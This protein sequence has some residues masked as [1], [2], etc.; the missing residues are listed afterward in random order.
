MSK[1]I[2]IVRWYDYLP[3]DISVAFYKVAMAAYGPDPFLGPRMKYFPVF[4]DAVVLATGIKSGPDSVD[5]GV[6]GFV[7][8]RKLP[9]T[10]NVVPKGTSVIEAINVS[11]NRSKEVDTFLD[12]IQTHLQEN[13]I[14]R[15]KAITAEGGFL[16]LSPISPAGAIY[17]STVEREL[18]A[19]VW[20]IMEKPLA[21]VSLGIKLPRKVLFSG[22]FGSGKT[23]AML[24]TAKKAVERGW[25]FI[26]VPSTI[27]AKEKVLMDKVIEMARYYEP[28][29]IA[30][31]DIDREQRS[32]DSFYLGNLATAIDGVTSKTSRVMFI[33][34][35]N[36]P[37][38]IS[39]ALQRP[40]RIDKVIDF[41]NYTAEDRKKLLMARIPE[42]NLAEDVD[43]KFVTET[44]N[45]FPPA[46]VREVADSAMLL[47]L[48]GNKDGDEKTTIS[49]ELLVE[50]ALGLQNQ[51]KKTQEALGFKRQ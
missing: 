24:I 22:P 1:R 19:H 45:D 35:T 7:E 51:H 34:S 21:C 4:R 39:A 49:T 29:V 18:R 30:W 31:E 36:Y 14:Y 38:K 48:D 15:G 6:S 12:K 50:A 25:T 23:L 10:F 47:A 42:N 40:G 8:L 11:A 20:T 28:A 13:S 16:D 44:C 3:H 27:E 9:G 33:L 26:N 41:G 17:N 43:W 2:S 5:S 32:C 37:D 46:F